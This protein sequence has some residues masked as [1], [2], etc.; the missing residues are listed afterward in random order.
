VVM[1]FE[2]YSDSEVVDHLAKLNAGLSEPWVIEG[3]KLSK[4]FKFVDF[5]TAFG[6]MTK[7]A[8]YVEKVN[9]HPEWFNVYNTL[10][11]QLTTHEVSG[12]SFKD[13]DLAQKM[14]AF[15]KS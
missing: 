8:I 10:K 3:G 11:V 13:F 6:F 2:K 12:I 5:I 15:Y 14:E 9:H 7:C 1:A 4:T